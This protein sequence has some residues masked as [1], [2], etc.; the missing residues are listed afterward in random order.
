[1]HVLHVLHQHATRRSYFVSFAPGT[2]GDIATSSEIVLLMKTSAV[3]P[4]VII[5]SFTWALQCGM[6]GL[7]LVI[8]EEMFSNSFVSLHGRVVWVC[9][10]LKCFKLGMPLAGRRSVQELGGYPSA[11]PV[12]GT[13]PADSNP[14]PLGLST[15]AGEL[16]REVT[17]LAP[18]TEAAGSCR[19]GSLLSKRPVRADRI[20]E[21]VDE[22]MTHNMRCW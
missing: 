17:C 19:T 21:A 2:P 9:L 1:V 10:G 15:G 16:L 8:K 18:E 13:T 4:C 3:L 5:N 14:V 11:T 20:G 6:K 12:L 7:T 22:A